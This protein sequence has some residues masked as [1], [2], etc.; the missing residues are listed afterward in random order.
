MR[1]VKKRRWA[2]FNRSQPQ[3]ETK[4]ESSGDDSPISSEAK[5]EEE[6][7]SAPQDHAASP[8]GPDIRPSDDPAP[9]SRALDSFFSRVN[10]VGP[11]SDLE[12]WVQ[13]CTDDLLLG[14]E[15]CTRH[16][17]LPVRLAL[18]DLA[19]IL[20]SYHQAG[21]TLDCLD[22]LKSSWN[23]FSVMTGDIIL[24][25]IHDGMTLRWQRLVKAVISEMEKADIPLI[26]DGEEEKA[27]E[28]RIETQQKEEEQELSEE[29]LQEEETTEEVAEETVS[30]EEAPFIMEEAV[31]DSEPV[32]TEKDS[33]I[34][35]HAEDAN[36]D[37]LIPFTL[38]PLSGDFF[39]EPAEET[40]PADENMF[41]FPE[42]G[43][44]QSDAASFE[45]EEISAEPEAEE[46]E[47]EDS[48]F[49]ADCEEEREE[50]EDKDG[51]FEDEDLFTQD[52]AEDAEEDTAAFEDDFSDA[53]VEEE[54]ENS[55]EE[56][57]EEQEP[58]L[59]KEEEETAGPDE[60]AEVEPDIEEEQDPLG[61]VD[62]RLILES[63]QDSLS[64]GD[65]SRTREA[66]LLLTLAMDK[67]SYED[68]RQAVEKAEQRL[69]DNARA[70]EEA[71]QNV[72]QAHEDLAQ[73]EEQLAARE[74]ERNSTRE[75]IV[76]ID[77]EVS[78]I[79]TELDELGKQIAVL[80]LKRA[81][82]NE[83]LESTNQRRQE[84]IAEESRLQTEVES[85]SQEVENIHLY[86]DDLQADQKHRE[87]ERKLLENEITEAR[88]VMEQ[89]RSLLMSVE[90]ILTANQKRPQPKGQEPDAF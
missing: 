89:N 25:K 46:Q 53:S 80:E 88:D 47:E 32:E 39:D 40:E 33:D 77:S 20:H 58:E 19:R 66:A 69:E 87:T 26:D 22:F 24:G 36:Q 75:T 1:F 28:E 73:M 61:E 12:L 59:R 86:V 11:E 43:E 3:T 21:K 79:I 62:D 78:G 72:K 56:T 55:P 60:E 35:S 74:E 57:V 49:F 18:I 37:N 6:T 8:S 82:R 27:L 34:P 81:A 70:I 30:E 29:P 63:L 68:S 2:I 85:L 67:R 17:W 64:R 71:V 42:S 48:S 23:S 10:Q 13:E 5:E 41:P 76:Q 51:L 83:A 44:A 84:A 50:E 14:I 52:Q 54:R 4:T 90:D 31:T 45:E 16:H 38:P 15:L 65:I 7:M 9:L